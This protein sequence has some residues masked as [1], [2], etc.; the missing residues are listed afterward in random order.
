MKSK[1]NASQ[2]RP[3]LACSICSTTHGQLSKYRGGYV[4]DLCAESNRVGCNTTSKALRTQQRANRAAQDLVVDDEG[5]AATSE[6][7]VYVRTA[8][9]LLAADALTTPV[10]CVRLAGGELAAARDVSPLKLTAEVVSLE[11]S[12]E[13]VQLL[14]SLGNDI[15]ALALDTAT[16]VGA[17][18]SVEQMLAHQIAASHHQAMTLLASAAVELD[19]AHQLR[20]SA[21]A[22]KW[23]GACQTAILALKK[24][25]ASGEQRIT[26]QHVN[27]S[28]GGQAVI[29]SIRSG[30]D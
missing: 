25:K 9:Q 16:A 23:M 10:E 8:G 30:G 26:I 3:L 19:Q 24:L 4:C 15:A 5:P 18:G 27:V 20:L 21:Q 14:T 11:A 17:A 13:R 29:G 1:V 28:D 22:A 6:H 7:L 12:N 2:A